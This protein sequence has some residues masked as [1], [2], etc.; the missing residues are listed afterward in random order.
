MTS[1]REDQRALD[2]LAFWMDAGPPKWFAGGA[3]FDRACEAY[4][5]LWEEGRDGALSTWSETVSGSLAL[6]IL[7]DQIPRNIFRGEAKQFST[8]DMAVALS[9]DAMKAG[10]DKVVMAPMRAF[11]YMPLMHAEDIALQRQ[12]CDLFRQSDMKDNYHYA[13]VHMD[14]ISRFGRFPHRNKILGRETTPEEQ[15]YLESGGFGA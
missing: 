12:C 13:L 15:A 7:L 10:F 1:G 11:F 4:E 6:I 9:L 5:A 14:A 8:D 3:K 2:L